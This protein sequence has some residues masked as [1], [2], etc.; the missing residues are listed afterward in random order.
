V[1]IQPVRGVLFLRECFTT[2]QDGKAKKKKQYSAGNAV[3][4]F[5]QSKF[6]LKIFYLINFIEQYTRLDRWCFYFSRDRVH[7]PDIQKDD[8]KLAEIIRITPEY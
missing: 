8:S 4:V 7:S 1:D 3:G 5:F 2:K 6:F